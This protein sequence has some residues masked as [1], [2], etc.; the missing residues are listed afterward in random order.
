MV[1]SITDCNLWKSLGPAGAFC[2]KFWIGVPGSSWGFLKHYRVYPG[3]GFLKALGPLPEPP[4]P[5]F[6]P[7]AGPIQLAQN[8]CLDCPNTGVRR[9]PRGRCTLLHAAAR[10]LHAALCARALPILPSLRLCDKNYILYLVF[11][12]FPAELGPETRSTGS[13]STNCA[14]RAQH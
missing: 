11:G 12:R 3:P 14:E 6:R 5:R 8:D 7:A 2:L 10:L 1:F 9:L 13:G 4:R